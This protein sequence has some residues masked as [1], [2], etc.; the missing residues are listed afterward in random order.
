MLRQLPYGDQA[1]LNIE[2]PAE[3]ELADFS[4]PPGSPLDDPAG[5]VASALAAPLGFPP[6]C[7]AIVPG[8]RIVVALDHDVP[9]LPTLVAGITRTLLS[10]G[11]EPDD[12]T[13][14][15]A[16]GAAGPSPTSRLDAA[17]ARSIRLAQHDPGD[18]GG[19]AY[20]AAS[21]EAL[22]IYV[23]RQ[24]FDADVIVPLGCLHPRTA[25]GYLGWAG[26]L[27]PTFSDAATQ[28]RFRVP[29]SVESRAAHRRQQKEAEE[30]AWLLGS[31]F[32]CQVV[33]GLGESI[34]HVLAG[35]VE[36]VAKL[37]R[38]LCE[39]AWRYRVPRRASLVV[40]TISGGPEQQ[41]WE[42][43][44]R[45]LLSASA[46]VADGGVIVLCTN[47]TCAPGP[48]LQQLAKSSEEDER[49]LRRLRRE[50]SADAV[51]AAL[52]W[53]VRQRAKVYLLSGLD[54]DTVEELG[55]GYVSRGEEVNRLSQHHHS[56]IL[57]ADAHRAVVELAEEQP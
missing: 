14:L 51:S 49:T 50:G 21:K 54:E 19:L 8:D 52:L 47:L 44:A 23:N 24:L 28:Q 38:E 37:G 45:A 20:L 39:A 46:V 6:L 27:F 30:A 40:S 13:L 5:A 16:H 12:I 7:Q 31:R 2:P 43:F 11:A 1:L 48:A 9:Q 18:Q 35:D 55:L 10:A 17:L 53:D 41:T 34:L 29:G 36:A 42:S 26:G 25:L 33:P 22:P 32:S 56:C 3:A 15:L 57:M 4:T